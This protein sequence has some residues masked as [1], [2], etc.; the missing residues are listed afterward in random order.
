MHCCDTWKHVTLWVTSVYSG[1]EYT[2]GARC[3][4]FRA[5]TQLSPPNWTLIER[6]YTATLAPKKQPGNGYHMSFLQSELNLDCI[7]QK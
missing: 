2:V 6:Y 7:Q 3:A 1:N 4:P 5:I